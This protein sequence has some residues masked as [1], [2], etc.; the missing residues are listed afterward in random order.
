MQVWLEI[1][2][3]G[4]QW[5]CPKLLTIYSRFALAH[6]RQEMLEMNSNGGNGFSRSGKTSRSVECYAMII[7]C[8]SAAMIDE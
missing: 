1:T 6:L 7:S 2:H 8:I 3:V 4:G 5:R